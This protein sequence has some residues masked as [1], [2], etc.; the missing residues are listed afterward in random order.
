MQCSGTALMSILMQVL[1]VFS[2]SMK[3]V[4]SSLHWAIR[5]LWTA[6]IAAF[7]AGNG[8]TGGGPGLG[9][10]A[11]GAA[12]IPVGRGAIR[13]A[14]GASKAPLLPIICRQAVE[15]VWSHAMAS[16]FHGR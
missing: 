14:A 16:I 6:T 15:L 9:L 8:S 2:C 11:N 4:R 7:G 5:S 13:N 12:T 3:R 10:A 1:L